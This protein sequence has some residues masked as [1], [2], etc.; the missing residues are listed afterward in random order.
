MNHSITDI[1]IN[2]AR[3]DKNEFKAIINI[4]S[5]VNIIID[6]K[7]KIMKKINYKKQKYIF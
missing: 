1:I 2:Q 7:L 5:K 6:N 3:K 4:I